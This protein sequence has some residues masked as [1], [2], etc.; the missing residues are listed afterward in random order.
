MSDEGETHCEICPPECDDGGREHLQVLEC[1]LSA[2]SEEIRQAEHDQFRDIV[3]KDLRSPVKAR[4]PLDQSPAQ[5]YRVSQPLLNWV[6]TLSS[7]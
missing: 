3:A 4:V 7:L 1:A 2:F 5:L 6:Y